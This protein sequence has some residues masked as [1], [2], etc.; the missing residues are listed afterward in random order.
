MARMPWLG[1]R[2]APDTPSFERAGA[3]RMA[4]GAAVMVSVVALALGSACADVLNMPGGQTSLE[5]VPVGNPG[6]VPDTH[7][8]GYG[9]VGY[10][11][12][13][14]KYEVTAGQY[15]Q[16]LNK[17]A[18]TDTYGLYNTSMDTA[19]DSYGCNIKRTGSSGSYAYSVTSDWANRPVN[20]VSWGDAAR[21]AN[22]MTN[23]QPTGAQGSSTTEDGSYYLNGAISIEALQAVTRKTSARYVV[24]TEDEWYKAAYYSG[25]GSV[26]YDY[27]TGANSLP[28]NI[29]LDPDPGNNAN[30]HGSDYTIGAPYYR[31]PV[32]EFD[33]SDSPYGTLDQGGNVW[34]WNEAIIGSSRGLRGGSFGNSGDNLRASYR[35]YD[36][37]ADEYGNIGFRVSEVPEPG[38]MLLLGTG[39][40][41]LARFAHRRRR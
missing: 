26:Y 17:V 25:V 10:K 18:A 2:G 29:L 7:G 20:F 28:S 11:Y 22:W 9:S 37:P 19:N 4:I 21:F 5:F 14:G 27:P 24:P 39:L 35:G 36:S 3:M 31:T 30:F 8:A 16:F 1:L 41:A 34:E 38:T 40:A 6:N 12:N 33:N 23:G 32:G 13:V 15:T